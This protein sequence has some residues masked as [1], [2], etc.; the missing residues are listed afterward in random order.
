MST[1]A[2]AVTTTATTEQVA[3]SH[4]ALQAALTAAAAL[5][6]TVENDEKY[7]DLQAQTVAT[8]VSAKHVKTRLIEVSIVVFVFAFLIGWFLRA[9]I[10]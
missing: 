1:A 5:P 2:P 6:H 7:L 8:W 4:T 3:A 10:G 9:L